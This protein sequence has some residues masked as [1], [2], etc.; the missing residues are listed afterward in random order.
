MQVRS[1]WLVGVLSA[2]ARSQGGLAYEIQHSNK[3]RRDEK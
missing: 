1:L 3:F 2:S